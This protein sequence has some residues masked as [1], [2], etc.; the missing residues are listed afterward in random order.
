GVARSQVSRQPGGVIGRAP[1]GALLAKEL[2]VGLEREAHVLRSRHAPW[3]R[4]VVVVFL[5]AAVVLALLN[6]FGQ[7]PTVTTASVASATLT[8][9]SP[10]RLRGG[11]VFTSEYTVTAHTDIH[12]AV[13][14]FS[15]GWWRGMTLNAV[16]P[17]PSNESSSAQGISYEY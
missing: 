7:Q 10:E 3:P 5:A 12:D 9:D 13:L 6:T 2:P 15:A 16:A 4:R 14:L 8:V 17:Q 1:R 11:L